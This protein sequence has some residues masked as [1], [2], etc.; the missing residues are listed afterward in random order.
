MLP[1][2]R[3][4]L[5]W[6]TGSM[7][8]HRKIN[9]T[10]RHPVAVRTLSTL[11]CF[12]SRQGRAADHGQGQTSLR[13]RTPAHHLYLHRRAASFANRKIVCESPKDLR[14][15]KEF[16]NR[17]TVCEPQTGLR[18]TNRLWPMNANMPT[19][20]VGTA[21]LGGTKRRPETLVHRNDAECIAAH[22]LVRQ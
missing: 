9:P 19:T 6:L 15:A 8:R 13:L 18:I 17:K 14:I 22:F 11:D 12:S 20:M 3:S 4:M 10:S 2:A 16:A 5:C 21:D 7:V 1:D